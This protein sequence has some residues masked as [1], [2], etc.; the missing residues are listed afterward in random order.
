MKIASKLRLSA[1]L[2]VLSVFVLAAVS[3]WSYT[4]IQ[5][6]RE[7]IESIDAMR[8]RANEIYLLTSELLLHRSA[9][10]EQQWR[11]THEAFTTRLDAVT[12]DLEPRAKPLLVE[13]RRRNKA[14]GIIFPRLSESVLIAESRTDQLDEAMRFRFGRV[15]RE[16]GAIQ[17]LLSQV[18]R[19]FFEFR[20]RTIDTVALIVAA[21]VMII[22]TAGAVVSVGFIPRLGKQVMELRAVI[23]SIGAGNLSQS[24]PVDSRDEIGDVFREVDRMRQGLLESTEQLQQ[25]NRQLAGAK[26]HLETRVEERT[27]ELATANKEL[28]SFAYAVSHDLRAPLR[29]IH[30]FAQ[31]LL[32]DYGDKLDEQGQDFTKRLQAASVRLGSQIDGILRLSRVSRAK[33]GHK[34]VDLSRMASGVLE[35]LKRTDPERSIEIKIE[36]NIVVIG[37]EA[38]LRVALQNLLE[39]SWKFTSGKTKPRIELGTERSNGHLSYYV[40]DNGA[41]FD[42][43]Y[44]DKLFKPF[45]RLHS[46]R[47]FKGDGIGLATVARV[48]HR[49][50][51]KVWAESSPGN[52]TTVHFT[53]SARPSQGTGGNSVR[54]EPLD[55]AREG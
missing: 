46:T 50:D 55:G 14:L 43:A 12:V 37:D 18:E 30:G 40:R 54:A 45:Q 16:L 5:D 25:A 8:S 38:L 2:A 10:A 15:L 44:S 29:S 1:G 19:Y 24:V 27:A 53:I 26:A 36:P 35:E 13:V 49:H 28:E 33:I 21:G 3:T 9:R 4:R 41:G 23:Q 11:R 6:L 32:E 7:Q 20:D 39:N 52:G 31:A 47:E 17:S 22:L 51:G 42:M 48:V 34:K